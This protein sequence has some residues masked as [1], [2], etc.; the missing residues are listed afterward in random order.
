MFF[1]LQTRLKIW[2]SNSLL[3]CC[4]V[5]YCAAIKVE[6]RLKCSAQF[7][8]LSLF[9]SLSPSSLS[10]QGVWKKATKRQQQM[11]ARHTEWM[12]EKEREREEHTQT[13]AGHIQKTL[14]QHLPQQELLS[15]RPGC[16]CGGRWRKICVCVINRVTLDTVCV[17]LSAHWHGRG[18]CLGEK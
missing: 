17:C 1:K 9:L 8:L 16:V 12:E 3:H 11:T 15:K 7:F 10:P 14:N 13:G 6:Q 4:I 18:K 5:H 2:F